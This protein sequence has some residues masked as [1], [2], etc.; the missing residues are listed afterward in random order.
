VLKLN[1]PRKGKQRLLAHRSVTLATL[2]ASNQ[3]WSIDFMQDDLVWYRRFRTFNVNREALV[4][5]IDLNIPAQRVVWVLGRIVA[6]RG[7][8]PLSGRMDN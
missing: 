2:A 5:A 3:T 6:N 8:H 7:Y 1:F 4:I